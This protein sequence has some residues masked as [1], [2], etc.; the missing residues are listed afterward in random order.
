MWLKQPGKYKGPETMFVLLAL[1]VTFKGK[2]NLIKREFKGKVTQIYALVVTQ[3][4]KMNEKMW[5][6]L[7]ECI[8]LLQRKLG[9]LIFYHVYL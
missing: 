8:G 2:T 3:F 6:I 4:L 7:S 9:L 5:L 1:M